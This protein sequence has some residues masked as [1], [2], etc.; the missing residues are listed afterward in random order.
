[1]EGKVGV[2]IFQKYFSLDGCAP[3]KA[4]RYTLAIPGYSKCRVSLHAQPP[5]LLLNAAR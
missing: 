2:H 1:M 5:A 4:N 3:A